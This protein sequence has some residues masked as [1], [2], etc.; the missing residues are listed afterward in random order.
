MNTFNNK[1]LSW[2]LFNERVLQEAQDTDV[3]LLQRLRF[4]GIFSNN[5]D[6]FFK[7]RVATLLRLS[8]I[9]AAK[10][11]QLTGGYTPAELLLKV[12]EKTETLQNSFSQT[13]AEIR[14]EMEENGI[15]LI[16][17]T[18]LNEEQLQFCT[19]YFTSIISIRL[20]PL[21][22]RKHAE[23]PFLPDG[24]IYL[25]VKMNMK[26]QSRYAIIEVPVSDASPRFVV[27][28]PSAAGRSEVMFVDDIIKLFLD[29]I[30]FMFNYESIEAHTFKF[31]RD[32]VFTLD[33]DISK[34]FVEKMSEGLSQRLHG[35]VIRLTYDR[36]M[37]EDVLKLLA[38]KF[39]LKKS[40]QLVAGSRYHL[41]RDLM[42]FPKVNPALENE[43]YAPLP[44]RAIDPFESIIS[45]IKQHDILLY[46]PYHSFNHFINFL[47]EAAID[48]S[49]ESIYIT[50]YRTA[51][52]SKVINALQNAAKNGKKV[53]VLVEIKARFDEEQNI[54]NANTLQ[55]SGVKVLYSPESI[56]VH[57]KVAL[58]E[59]KEGS[60]KRKGYVYVGTG[61]F[62]EN[63]A[64]VY[65][66][67]GLFTAHQ[68]VVADARK[69]FDYLEN[70]H[71]RYEYDTLL[72]APYDLRSAINKI[73]NTEIENAKKGKKAYFYGKFNS[74]TDE[75]M[76][77]KLYKA[78]N[79]GVKI[80][81]IIR[82]A[83]CLQPQLKK[84]S[85]NIEIHSIVDTYL[86]HARVILHA[87]G[88]KERSYILSA[89]LMPRNLDRRVEV[90]TPIL[91]KK[92]HD[93]VR[94]I[95]NLQWQD[96]EKARL[97]TN[98]KENTYYAGNNYTKIRSQIA[99]YEYLTDKQ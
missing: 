70:T 58:V 85:E 1:E 88:G 36:E 14:A 82:G 95:F 94:T 32:A 41:M 57:S 47:R 3:P 18:Q 91:D 39:K 33:D 86:E 46:Y 28:P 21:M 19:N 76:I 26:T 99:L 8:D 13:Y 84:L 24:K 9:A 79:A 66:D 93:I 61:N 35:R 78:S 89:D 29:D 43:K 92:I 81:L 16:D 75:K 30:F 25:A 31:T 40:Q 7:V 38:H 23:I 48:P 56:K 62:N 17:H 27:L 74:L 15:F 20:V 37:P 34:S 72:V 71:K 50:L 83:C 64:T 68:S 98:D 53:T 55:E 49:V 11:A 59:R 5:Q 44:L 10:H 80:R 77:E 97:L 22:L 54:V 51:S 12:Y 90:G 42:K 60:G 65:C 87:N 4:L 52:H 63:T 6:E 96:N 2:L 73:L 69:L 67:F 45:V